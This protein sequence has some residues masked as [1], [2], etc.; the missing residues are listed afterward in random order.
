[1]NLFFITTT[2]LYSCSFSNRTAVRKATRIN[3][4]LTFLRP[5]ILSEFTSNI[6]FVQTYKI[7]NDTLKK[8][9]VKNGITELSIQYYLNENESKTTQSLS[10]FDSLIIFHTNKSKNERLVYEDIIYSFSS[11]KPKGTS[12]NLSDDAKIK[13]IND[14]LWLVKTN[15]KVV[16]IF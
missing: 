13:Q 15:F 8:Y 9:F 7:Q 2:F 12:L 6:L 11:R 4:D 14:S 5:L 16:S 3:A 1:M 10:S